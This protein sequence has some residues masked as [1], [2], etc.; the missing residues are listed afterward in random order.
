MRKISCYIFLVTYLIS[1]VS[2]L[3][4]SQRNNFQTYSLEQGLPQAT[5]YCIIQDNRGYLWLGTDGGGLCR[6][7]GIKFKTYGKKEG[8]KGY[9]IRSLLQDRK[10]RIW[11]GTKDQGIIIYDG[12]KFTSIEKN[13]GLAGDA[14]LCMYEDESGTVWAGTDNGGLNKI[15]AEA[16]SFKVEVIDESKGLSNNSV[17]NI[18]QD[19]DKHLWLATFGGVNILTPLSVGRG[20]AGVTNTFQIDQLRGGREIPSDYILSIGEDSEGALWFGTL[21]E[22]VFK[23]APAKKSSQNFKLDL[24]SREITRYNQSNGFT[25]KKVWNILTTSNKELWFA[26]VENGIVRQRSVT[27]DPSKYVFENYTNKEGLMGNE[28]LCIYEDKERNIW[29]GTNGYG[30]CKFMG[31]IFAHYSEKDGLPSNAIRAVDQ[32]SL[33]NFWLGTGGGGIV[34]LQVQNGVPKCENYSM[35]NGLQGNTINSISVGKVAHNRNIWAVVADAGITKFNPSASLR[36]GYKSFQNFSEADEILDNSAYSILVDK[37]GIVWVGTQ[38]GINRFDGVKF[39]GTT[40]EKMKI[41]GKGV[42][43]IIQDKNEN[44]WFGT[45]GG[46]AKYD[47]DGSIT[48]FDEMEGLMHKEIKCLAEDPFGNIWIGTSNGGVYR[49]D[50]FTDDKMKIRQIAD[51]SLL[52]SN[53]VRAIIFLDEK[54]SGS[55]E[56]EMVLG[57]DKGVVKITFDDKGKNLK[58]RNYDASDGF[59]GVECND[60]AIYKDKEGN[61]W[62]GTVKGLTRYNPSIQNET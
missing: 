2:Y 56:K 15:S 46:L 59:I 19:K 20:T 41:D 16:D 5:I 11:A 58:V 1:H 21:E 27:A 34:K 31:D 22:G 48:T 60:N 6:F 38:Q 18:H 50:V 51:D 13:N 55:M 17:F 49:F 62:F 9:T 4:F 42:Y 8:F 29:I 36:T 45:K 33:G 39:L 37:N 24:L 10:G 52:S 30:L 35:T 43:A 7:D 28:A 61:I 3:A 14:V 54:K 12:L 23:I 53:S 47:R 25:A 26:S 57:T 40:M 32:D 44:L